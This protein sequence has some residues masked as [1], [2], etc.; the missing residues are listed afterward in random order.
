[1]LDRVALLIVV[2]VAFI[3]VIALIIPTSVEIGMIQV[4]SGQYECA[5]D[6]AGEWRCAKVKP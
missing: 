6:I 4:A 2:F 5:K 1:M 3:C